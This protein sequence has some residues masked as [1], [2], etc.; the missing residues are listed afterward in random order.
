MLVTSKLTKDDKRFLASALDWAI[1]NEEELIT[2]YGYEPD[3]Q[4]DAD[5]NNRKVIESTQAN[6]SRM[7]RLQIIL[8]A[9]AK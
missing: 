1:A 6:I 5:D 2:A 3:E 9:Q 4:L 8:R 7:R